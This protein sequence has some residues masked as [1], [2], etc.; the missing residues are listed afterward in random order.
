MKYIETRLTSHEVDED[1]F[2]QLVENGIVDPRKSDIS[3][4]A[5]AGPRQI[6]QLLDLSE[7]APDTRPHFVC[8]FVRHNDHVLLVKKT[9]PT[10]QS[11]RW[12]GVGGRV[13]A[14]E[15]M[16]DAM[17]RE[18]MEETTL[19]PPDFKEFIVLEDSEVV[20][21]FFRATITTDKVH[22]LPT[23]DKG[24]ELEWHSLIEGEC[25]YTDPHRAIDNL[26]WLIP[27]AMSDVYHVTG[28]VIA[29]RRGPSGEP[30]R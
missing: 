24:E 11:G 15:S 10:W 26:C 21:H 23:N 6:H 5:V 30:V 12:N 2:D 22:T 27:M 13:E 18:W 8:A 9:H 28:R 14:G 20:V 25:E 29:W 7:C 3:D 1:I 4:H 17:E 19:A 16:L